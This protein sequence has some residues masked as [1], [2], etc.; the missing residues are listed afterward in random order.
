MP[1]I[2]VGIDGS[3]HSHFALEWAMRYAAQRLSA[4]RHRLAAYVVLSLL[5]RGTHR[6][7][8]ERTA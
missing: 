6:G 2:V 7:G 3:Q 1:G 5:S 4:L 8:P